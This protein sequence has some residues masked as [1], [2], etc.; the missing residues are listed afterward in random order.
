M[1]DTRSPERR[2]TLGSPPALPDAE[3]LRVVDGFVAELQQGIDQHDAVVY[4]RHFAEDVAWG[5]PFGAAVHGYEPLH[6]IH[7]RLQAAGVG[8][9]ASRYEVVSVL[10]PSADLVLAHVARRTLD[11][12]GAPLPPSAA[13]AQP[14]SE[15]ALYVL[16]RRGEEWWLAAGQNTP[17][18]PGGAAP[19]S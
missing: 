1:S 19:S 12:D 5:G 2:P 16:V 10:A 18:R 13:D 6:A 8:G 3:A 7:R 15:M 11:D 17:I 9:P 4:N 14:F